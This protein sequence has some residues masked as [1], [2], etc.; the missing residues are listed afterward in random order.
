MEKV[1]GICPKC[2][3][4]SINEKEKFCPSCGTDLISK[5]PNCGGQINHPLARFCPVCGVEYI[6]K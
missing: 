1:L 3:F 2:G 5:C 4:V 6:K